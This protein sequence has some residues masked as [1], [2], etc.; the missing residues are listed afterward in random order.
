MKLLLLGLAL[1]VM[2]APG[3]P[4]NSDPA[5]IDLYASFQQEPPPEVLEAIQGELNRIMTPAGM[6]VRWRLGA[7]A[8]EVSVELAVV[9]FVG[10]CDVILTAHPSAPIGALGWT[11]MSDGVILPFTD[12]SCD[13]VRDLMESRLNRESPRYREAA[14]GRALARVLAHELYHILARTTHHDTCGVARSAYTAAELLAPRF[15]FE[16]S[17]AKAMRSMRPEPEA[18]L[19]QQAPGALAGN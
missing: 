7:V 9:K 17:E 4:R 8:K 12:I 14:F 6:P 3:E 1:A 13:A 10:R 5:P 2:Q 19:D 15:R 11:H 16:P 18:P